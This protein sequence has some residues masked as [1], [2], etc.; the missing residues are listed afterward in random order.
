[1]KILH[2]TLL[3]LTLVSCSGQVKNTET[4]INTQNKTTIDTT[5]YQIDNKIYQFDTIINSTQYLIKTYCLNDSAIY[6]KSFSDQGSEISVAHNYASD[7]T[8][9]TTEKDLKNHVTKESFKKSIPSD[10]MV[11]CHMYKN[12]FLQFDKGEPLFCATLAE[13][14][15]DNQFSIYYTITS[16]GIIKIIKVENQAFEG[17]DD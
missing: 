3:V 13:P 16:E 2:L 17:G 6:I 12:E 14:D 15:T 1:M 9:K 5:Y 10:F 7:I 11:K 4:E 8:I